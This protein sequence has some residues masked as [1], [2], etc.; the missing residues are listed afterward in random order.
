MKRIAA[1]MA[2]LLLAAPAVA[3]TSNDAR[4]GEA[5]AQSKPTAPGTQAGTSTPAATGETWYGRF[6][7]DEL[8][9]KN[10]VNAKGDNVGEIEDVVVDPSSKAMYAV[11]SVGGFLGIGDKDVAM[12]F[13]QLRLGADDAILIDLLLRELGPE[14][15][16]YADY[17]AFRR[18]VAE[19]DGC[20]PESVQVDCDDWIAARRREIEERRAQQRGGYAPRDTA[21]AFRIS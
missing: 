3:Q 10:V 19:R 5:M 13:D 6:S 20:A 8:I 15:A 7:A 4:G 1:L 18:E 12:S 16:D 14:L 17:C 11:V 2:I 9:G 21:R